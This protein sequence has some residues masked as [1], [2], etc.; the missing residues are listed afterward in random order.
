LLEIQ[1]IQRERQYV[2]SAK[3][4]APSHCEQGFER[5]G[6]RLDN[7]SCLGAREECYWP[8]PGG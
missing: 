3:A 8:V 2:A 1:V 6:G 5:L 4:G 7:L